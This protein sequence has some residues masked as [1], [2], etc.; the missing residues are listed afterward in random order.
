MRH[1]LSLFAFLFV[2]WLLFSGYFEPLLLTLGLLSC[3]FVVWIAVRQNVVDHEGHPVHL[4]P[5]RWL[6]YTVWLA[7]E[8]VK[9]N[10]DVA[11]RIWNP[12]LPIS[13]TVV[14]VPA[15]MNELGQ[16]IYANSITLTPGT[17]SIDLDNNVITVHA[18]TREGAEELSKG[19]MARRVQGV[20]RQQ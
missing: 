13:P 15:D 9:A 8:I 14:K 11:A 10:I 2:V 20:G 6:S 1:N 3:A 16:V 12:K 17:V 19:E 5:V 4:R 18:L 7:G